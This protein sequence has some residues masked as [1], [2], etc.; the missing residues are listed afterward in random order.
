VACLLVAV[1]PRST[2]PAAEIPA[3]IVAHRYDVD[4]QHSS[5]SFSATIFG[6]VKVRGR[7]TDYAS[8]VVYDPAHPERSSVVAVIATPSLTTDMK[9][10][11]D[12]LRS[13]DFFDVERFP[14]IEFRSDT[15][16]P[17]SDGLSVSG[18][19]T[20]HGVSRRMTIPVTIALP[21]GR[22][23]GG[24]GHVGFS[25]A[26]RLSRRS[27]GILGDN[28]F[29]PSYNP[30]TS[31]LSDSIDVTLDLFALQPSYQS[32]VLGQGRPPGVADTVFKALLARGVDQGLALYRQLRSSRPADFS[33]SP[34]QLDKIGHKL[35]EAGRLADAVTVLRYNAELFEG[36]NGVLES[37]GEV[38]A[39]GNDRAGA[40][41]VYRRA[42]DRFPASVSARHMIALLERPTS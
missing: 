25:A 32:M 15:V 35:A 21:P 26:L 28:K 34:G 41:A 29:N 18:V 31:T 1:G 42:A 36:T 16:A 37:L 7:F 5:I 3:D 19:L 6:A 22:S 9:F 24:D 27:F 30:L 8:S 33:F 10:R 20:M 23:P 4:S 14:T 13:P 40:L 38:L 11:D 39:L 2:A 12:H 17:R